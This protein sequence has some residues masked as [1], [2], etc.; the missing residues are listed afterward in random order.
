VLD[1]A[2]KGAVGQGKAAA[3]GRRDGEQQRWQLIN[4]RLIS[5]ATNNC[6]PGR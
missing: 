6:Y 4:T 2:A 1:R 3:D 5:A